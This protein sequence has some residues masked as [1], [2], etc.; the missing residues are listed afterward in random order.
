MFAN[1]H[2]ILF[3]IDDLGYPDFERQPSGTGR[4]AYPPHPCALAKNQRSAFGKEYAKRASW[5]GLIRL[6]HRC[7]LR[8]VSQRLQQ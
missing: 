7:L 2:L 3:H 5:I 1:R 4:A 8:A 6:M